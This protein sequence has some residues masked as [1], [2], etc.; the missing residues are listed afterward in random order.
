MRRLHEEPL[1]S[2]YKLVERDESKRQGWLPRRM[3]VEFRAKGEEHSFAVALGSCLAK[4]ARETVMDGFN[5]YFHNLQPD[6]SPTAGYT[7]DGRR[8]LQDAK[9]ALADGHLAPDVLVRTR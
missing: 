3:T 1:L 6:L 9:P 2:S 4:Y 8:W 5:R 7:T